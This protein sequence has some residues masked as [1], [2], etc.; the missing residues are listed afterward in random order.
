VILAH[1]TYILVCALLCAVV[2][3]YWVVVDSVRLRAAL[4][5]D[6]TSAVTRDKR[7]G[8]MI[9]IIVGLFGVLGILKYYFY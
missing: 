8:S 7:F 3:A 6:G 4:R 5:E 1:D 2:A 9:G